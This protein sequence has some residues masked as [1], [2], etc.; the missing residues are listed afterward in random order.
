MISLEAWRG[1][2]GTWAGRAKLSSTSG[3]P[4]FDI[5]F[6]MDSDIFRVISTGLLAVVNYILLIVSGVEINPGPPRKDLNYTS[7]S[8]EDIEVP[9]DFEYGET[10]EGKFAFSAPITPIILKEKRRV[11]VSSKKCPKIFSGH[12]N[13][14][15]VALATG[16]SHVPTNSSQTSVTE[17]L[18]CS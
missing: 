12:I 7:S 3:R 2:I 5:S 10:S 6:G 13:R 14:E 16:N 11:V 9:K 17:S 1:R 8:E 15:K 18:G 4:K